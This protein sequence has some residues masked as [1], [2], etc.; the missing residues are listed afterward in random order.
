MIRLILGDF[1][2]H[3]LEKRENRDHIVKG[4]DTNGKLLIDPVNLCDLEIINL[5]M[6]CKGQWTWVKDKSNSR[7]DYVLMNRKIDRKLRILFSVIIASIL[8]RHN[9]LPTSL[10]LYCG[11]VALES[12]R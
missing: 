4:D 3:V 8:N 9:F 2:G 5:N 11:G 10:S 7:I 1:N 12:E 6:K